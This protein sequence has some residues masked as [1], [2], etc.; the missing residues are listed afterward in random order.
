MVEKEE[1]YRYFDANKTGMVRRKE[2]M[3]GMQ[4]LRSGGPVG[5]P[6]FPGVKGHS[7]PPPAIEALRQAG[8]D[9]AAN[10]A[11]VTVGPEDEE[12]HKEKRKR[13]PTLRIPLTY[14]AVMGGREF[15]GD[16]PRA[17]ATFAP[18]ELCATG[19][20]E[21]SL[22]PVPDIH[23]KQW[24]NTYVYVPETRSAMKE[25]GQFLERFVQGDDGEW[26]DYPKAERLAEHIQYKREKYQEE[27]RMQEAI[28]SGKGWEYTG[29]DPTGKDGYT[30][31]Y[32]GKRL[33]V[34]QGKIMPKAALMDQYN[35]HISEFRQMVRDLVPPAD[36]DNFRLGWPGASAPDRNK[37]TSQAA[38]DW[39]DRQNPFITSDR[40]YQFVEL[41]SS[42]VDAENYGKWRDVGGSNPVDLAQDVI[43][44]LKHPI[45]D[46]P[47]RI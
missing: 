9:G 2:F 45:D 28:M 41:A 24:Y 34:H 15:Y 27:K 10:A 31:P 18:S 37:S 35:V 32:S 19:D 43:T 22:A 25:G 3:A 47:Y 29:S 21:A 36:F 33:V 17:N 14:P 38:Y 11:T 46:Y 16:I 30:C 12:F 7:L 23:C 26:L 8:Y 5:S 4:Q 40:N 39:Y 1:L 44:R 20:P 13:L 6:V 42:Y